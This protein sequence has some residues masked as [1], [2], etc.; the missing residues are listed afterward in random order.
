MEL[1]TQIIYLLREI[2]Y[3]IASVEHLFAMLRNLFKPRNLCGFQIPKKPKPRQGK[4][5]SSY[6]NDPRNREL[7]HE[8]IGLLRGDIATA[9]RLLKHQRR[10]H[11]GQSDNWYLEKVIHDLERDRH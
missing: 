7:Q 2:V 8:L 1:L 9:K 4:W 10:L 3:L 5:S 6:R 11:P